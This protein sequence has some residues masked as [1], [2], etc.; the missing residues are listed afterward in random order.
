M[1]TSGNNPLAGA[2]DNGNESTLKTWSHTGLCGS[3]I[4]HKAKENNMGI[5]IQPGEFP[6]RRR[7]D[8]K[9]GAEARVFDAI[10]ELQ[11][12]GRAIYEFRLREEGMQVDFALWL[13][14]LGRFALQVKGG[15][16]RLDTDGQWHLQK[17]DGA[18]A[19]V[20]SPM[21]ETV[22]GRI[23]MHDAIDEATGYYGFVVGVLVF[24]DMERDEQMERVARNHSHLHIIWGLDDLAE[25][26]KRIARQ[27][28]IKRKLWPC[29]SENEWRKVNELQFG[30]GESR[31]DGGT[32]TPASRDGETTG[33]DREGSF[34]AESIT[35][36]IQRVDRLEVRHYHPGG[37]GD[38][39]G[40]LP[41]E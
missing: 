17:L 3:S 21:E 27:V 28:G 23:E 8:P 34:S 37:E 30:G 2:G 35:I 10:R 31:P 38:G 29:H 14:R 19:P 9:R 18:W 6:E 33:G 26:L 11:L 15:A 16:Y 24:P 40:L 12:P 4:P 39:K 13:D 20:P 36:S 32:Q 22:D 25:D 41:R 5:Q 1:S 7:H